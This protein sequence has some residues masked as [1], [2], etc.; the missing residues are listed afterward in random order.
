MADPTPPN[1]AT[2]LRDYPWVVLRFRCH[3]C[4][5]AGDARLAVLSA[6][7]GPNET[8]GALL[9]IFMGRCAWSSFNPA[10]YSPQKYGR[11]CGGY[12][13]DVTRTG[14]PDWPPAMRGLSLIEGG[15]AEMMPAEPKPAERRRRVGGEQ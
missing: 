15:A 8:I 10:N 3:Y 12:L 7:Y 14:P 1:E 4:R 9:R 5:R 6:R 11:K 13:P 2:T